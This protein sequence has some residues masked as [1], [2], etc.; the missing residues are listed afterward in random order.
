MTLF[1]L[2]W[3]SPPQRELFISISGQLSTK[4][5]TI[6]LA[7]Y[8]S[9]ACHAVVLINIHIPAFWVVFYCFSVH[10]RHCKV[11]FSIYMTARAPSALMLTDCVGVPSPLLSMDAS[12][13]CC[14]RFVNTVWRRRLLRRLFGVLFS[15][16]CKIGITD[17]H[18]LICFSIWNFWKLL[19][20]LAHILCG[21]R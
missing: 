19:R 12:S 9:Y 18:D 14:R 6:D 17:G 21:L 10:M 2:I 13:D 4:N 5:L 20:W 15:A 3:D 7:V 11:H 16:E 1:Q 8:L